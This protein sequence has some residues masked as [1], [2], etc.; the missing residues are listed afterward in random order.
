MKRLTL[1]ASALMVCALLLTAGPAVA[2]PLV[3]DPAAQQDFTMA[4]LIGYNTAGGIQIQDK[5]FHS[6]WYQGADETSFINA[7]L[8]FSSVGSEDTHG[9]IFTNT[10]PANGNKWVSS[11]NLGY[12]ITVAPQHKD[13]WIVASKDQI[14]VGLVP[15]DVVMTDQ[16]TIGLLVMDAN[17]SQESVQK[18]Y[19]G[20][21]SV[22]TSSSAVI[23][24]NAWIQSY[25]QNWF[26][27]TRPVPEPSLLLLLGAGLLGIAG[28][29]RK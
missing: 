5:I 6:F 14:N 4:D 7:H 11:F 29:R 28:L 23:G 27:K 15:K 25:E 17:A 19:A 2:A 9:W 8:V 20:V 3:V 16:Q 13:V 21:K 10:N 1:F 12:T 24:P 22:T 26:E 18:T